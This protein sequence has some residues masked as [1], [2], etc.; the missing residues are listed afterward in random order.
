VNIVLGDNSSIHGTGLGRIAVQMMAGGKWIC[1]VLQDVLYVPE[2]HGNLLSVSQLARC[3]A[4]VCFA[5]GGCQIYDQKGTLTCEGTLRGNLYLMP[6]RAEAHESARVAITQLDTFPADGMDLPLL[7]PDAAL[8]VHGSSPKADALTWHRRLGHL[9]IDAVLRMVCKGMVKGMELV[10]TTSLPSSA[11]NACLKGKQTRTE[12]Q[13][14]TELHANVVLGRIFS[15]VCGKLPTRSHRGFEYFVTWVDDK[16]RKVF[17]DGLR[18]KSEVVTHLKAF[19]ARAKLE[20]SHCLKVLRTDGGGEYIAKTVDAFLKDKGVQHEMTTPDTPQH[21]RV[22]E[23]MNRTL[24]NRV[25]SMLINASLPEA[26][27]YDALE[28]VALIQNVTPTH[29]LDNITPDEA[30]SGNKPNVSRL[31]AFGS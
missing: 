12:I 5:K 14:S 9:N 8:V 13:K 25:C 19:T 2:L 16:S 11:C 1:T 31:R 15:D 21:N 20:T 28:Y 7:I 10:G 4:D 18:E 30:W 17:I 6:I 29:A 3:G 23:C 26:Y 22:A 24:L 27:W